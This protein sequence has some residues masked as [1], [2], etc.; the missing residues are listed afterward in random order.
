MPDKFDSYMHDCHV[1]GRA[2]GATLVY[3]D[4]DG[5]RVALCNYALVPREYIG[6]AEW[7][8]ITRR[9]RAAHRL[10]PTTLSRS[11]TPESKP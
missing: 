7:A 4:A 2:D 5:V 8:A 1:V 3:A 11:P 9:M 10:A 6:P